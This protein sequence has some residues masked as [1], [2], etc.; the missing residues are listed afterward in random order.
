MNR[1]LTLAAAFVLIAGPSAVAAPA[2]PPNLHY[3]QNNPDGPQQRRQTRAP[4]R[5]Q[6]QNVPPPPGP[7]R[8]GPAPPPP[9][10]EQNAPGRQQGRNVPPPRGPSRAGPLPPRPEQDANRFR[11]TRRWDWNAYRPG[12]EPP[13]WNQYRRNF[14]M[15]PYQRNLRAE[16]RYQWMPYIPPPGF[17][18]RQ[19]FYGQIF[20][21]AFWPRDYWIT[22]YWMFGLIDPPYGY[23]W[24][25]Y[26]GDAVLVSVQTGV[27]LR[28]VYGVF[29]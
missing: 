8:A 14:D 25:R 24:V 21:T 6:G 27:I 3:A 5:Q 9:R 15:R 7:S 12:V 18:Y 16:Y 13:Q 29:Y 26:D 19:W 4:D 2:A 23:V 10:A 1:V 22:N 11:E 20:P 17:Y 28:V